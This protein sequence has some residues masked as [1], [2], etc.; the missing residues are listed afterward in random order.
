MNLVSNAI[1]FTQQG[2][3]TI[4]VSKM[5]EEGKH[6][7]LLFE[8]QDTGLGIPADRIAQFVPVV[9]TGRCFYGADLRRY[10]S[11]SCYL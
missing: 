8:V 3:I 9:F 4:H 1:K 10:R 11:W 2:G 6:V 7:E 5:R